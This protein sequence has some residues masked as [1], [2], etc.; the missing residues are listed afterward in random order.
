VPGIAGAIHHDFCG[1]SD[2]PL[3][4]TGILRV[5]SAN[6]QTQ[7]RNLRGKLT[8]SR[9]S[10]IVIGMQPDVRR[11]LPLPRELDNVHGRL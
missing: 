8:V 2:P 6:A 7:Q 11:D 9:G 5:V 3:Q 1:P 4:G 10:S